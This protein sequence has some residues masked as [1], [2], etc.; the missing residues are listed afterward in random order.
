MC[1]NIEQTLYNT[2]SSFLCRLTNPLH[3]NR[4]LF[5]S[6]SHALNAFM[7]MTLF[8]NVTENKYTEMRLL[9]ANKA[10]VKP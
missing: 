3:N 7:I 1:T 8:F 2:D 10:W 9:L 6:P 4:P 5:Y